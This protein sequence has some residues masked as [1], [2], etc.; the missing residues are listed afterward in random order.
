MDYIA[1][2][3]TIIFTPDYNNDLD[4]DLLSKFNKLIFSNYKL[5][6]KLFEVYGNL[7]CFDDIFCR[8]LK[9]YI[10]KFNKSVNNLP[11]S[12]THLFLVKILIK[13]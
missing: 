2:D 13:K 9:H 4:I 3:N 10:N 12:I 11:S 7:K 1:K 5:N 6:N 8:N